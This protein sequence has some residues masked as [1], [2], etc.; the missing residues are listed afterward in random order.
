MV[1]EA[2]YIFGNYVY[3]G[4]SYLLIYLGL[5]CT[6]IYFTQIIYGYMEYMF[7]QHLHKFTEFN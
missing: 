1:H 2:L 4:K 7:F 3:V 6:H 5:I